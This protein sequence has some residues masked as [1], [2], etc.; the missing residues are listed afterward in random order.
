[1]APQIPPASTDPITVSVKAAS[2]M[3]G[4]SAWQI[5]QRCDAGL[6]ESRFDGPRRL[7]VVE[8]LH[9]YVKSLP[10]TPPTGEVSA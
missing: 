1:M 3:L 10:T 2:A 7:V 6:I 5:K 9:A 4:L 8:S